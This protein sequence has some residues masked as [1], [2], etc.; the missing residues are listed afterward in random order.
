MKLSEVFKLAE[1]QAKETE[2]LPTGFKAIDNSLDGGFMKKELIVLGGHTGR[3]KSYVAGQIM[4][5]I[6]RKGFKCG[7]FSLEISNKMIVARL[8]G[9]ISNLK[10]TRVAHGFL[11][12]QEL[13]AKKEAQAELLAYEEFLDFHDDLYLLDDILK[14]I[15]EEALDF[16]IVDFVQ[17]VLV[18]SMPDEYARLSHVALQLQ[19]AAKELN[20]CILILSQLSNMVAREGARGRTTE[21]KGSGNIG[22][23]CDLGFFL[24]R[25]DYV[26]GTEYQDV[27][28]T[29]KKNRRGISGLDF[30]LRFQHPGGLIY[31]QR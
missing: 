23:V 9:A 1:E 18:K 25:E 19:K 27:T 7:Y 3:G 30:K 5:S 26:M 28:L 16:A 17:N 24:E 22:T 4:S 12:I 13:N 6:A 14:I 10:P 11:T 31:E 8:V 29:L 21:Y 15:K 20:V 2:F